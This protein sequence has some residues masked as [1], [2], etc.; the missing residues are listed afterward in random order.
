MAAGALA[1]GCRADPHQAARCTT[2]VGRGAEAIDLSRGLDR[3]GPETTEMRPLSDSLS[4]PNGLLGL[5]ME[6]KT[7]PARD[8][9]QKARRG[10]RGRRGC[11]ACG[12]AA[13][14]VLRA[15]PTALIL[16]RLDLGGSK[17]RCDSGRGGFGTR[18]A[19]AVKEDPAST[20][21]VRRRS[22]AWR[23]STSVARSERRLCPVRAEWPRTAAD[24]VHAL[25]R[26]AQGCGSARR[27]GAAS[28]GSA[29][30]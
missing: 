6:C 22:L 1:H 14:T 11:V 4:F 18:A 24:G 29:Q 13:R 5:G 17:T 10:R 23:C 19:S 27:G 26:G 16:R 8:A 12:R 28:A 20:F 15:P 25:C 30:A 21:V 3:G 2:R 7:N 9:T